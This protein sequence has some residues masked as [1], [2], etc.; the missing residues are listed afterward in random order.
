MA[1]RRGVLTHGSDVV[2]EWT[3]I[4]CDW[5]MGH[6]ENGTMVAGL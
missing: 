1:G 6:F 4:T 3:L 5:P 2:P